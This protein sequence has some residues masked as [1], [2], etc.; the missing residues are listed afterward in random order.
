MRKYIQDNLDKGVIGVLFKSLKELNQLTELYGRGVCLEGINGYS[1]YAKTD[2]FKT[3]ID[4]RVAVTEEK[5]E[6][7]KVAASFSSRF[8]PNVKFSYSGVL[9]YSKKPYT[10]DRKLIKTTYMMTSPSGELLLRFS[11]KPHYLDSIDLREVSIYEAIPEIVPEGMRYDKES[12]SLVPDVLHGIDMS[13]KDLVASYFDPKASFSIFK[14]NLKR[15]GIKLL[16]FDDVG[17]D[18]SNTSHQKSHFTLEAKVNTKI[19]QQFSSMPK[20]KYDKRVI[21]KYNPYIN[22]VVDVYSVLKAFE[23]KCPALQ[24]LIKKALCAGLRGHKGIETDLQDI[25]DSAIRAKELYKETK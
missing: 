15:N 21:D 3:L 8:M 16:C 4:F 23:V 1:I 17:L 9:D 10:F 25:I 18:N 2:E 5:K 22:S 19:N 20:N 6:V 14:Q 7:V 11:N 12:D 13:V 24:H